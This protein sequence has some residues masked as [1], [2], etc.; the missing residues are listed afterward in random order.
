[1]TKPSIDSSVVCSQNGSNKKKVKIR[2]TIPPPFPSLFSF[3]LT[4]RRL[5]SRLFFGHERSSG[6][7]KAAGFEV[8]MKFFP[9]LFSQCLSSGIF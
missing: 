5:I 6:A 1:M 8:P 3:L 9:V 4:A 2:R 7:Y